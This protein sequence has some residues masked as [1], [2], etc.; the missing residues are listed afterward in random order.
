VRGGALT[1]A[2]GVMVAIGIVASSGRPFVIGGLV[3][4]LL[5]AGSR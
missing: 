2:G 5:A 4:L 3:L 1:V